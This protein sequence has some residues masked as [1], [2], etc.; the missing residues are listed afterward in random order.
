MAG[1]DPSLVGSSDG[2]RLGRVFHRKNLLQFLGAHQQAVKKEVS[3]TKFVFK[4]T[5]E[6]LFSSLFLPYHG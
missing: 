6:F 4:S 5:L 1:G 2:A 3:Q